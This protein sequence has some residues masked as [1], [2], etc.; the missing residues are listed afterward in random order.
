MAGYQHWGVIGAGA[1]GTSLAQALVRAGRDVTLWAREA[2]VV[3]AINQSH[4]NTPFLPKVRLDPRLKATKNLAD[5]AP[6][7]AWMLVAPAQHTRTL[8]EQLASVAGGR[9]VPAVLCSKGI[10]TGSLA[11]L[12]DIVKG[13]LPALPVAILSGPSFAIEVAQDQPTALTLACADEVLAASLCASISSRTLRP[14][15]SADVIGAQIGGAVKNVLAVA[16]GI[17]AG[18]GM[19]ENARAALITRGLAEMARLGLALGAKTETLMGLSGLGDLVLTCSSTQSRNMSLGFELGRGRTLA[20]ILAERKTVAEGVPTS[21]AAAALAMRHGV[22][23]PIV[24]GVD[25]ILNKGANV[26]EVI[27]G[28]LTRP[29]RSESN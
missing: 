24:M 19:G 12:S 1:W 20:D 17:A 2:E 13:V 23:M 25:S 3:D 7:E 10:E 4:C 6:C 27:E 9:A 26:A 14:Y 8:C 21:A 28:L 22:D 29:L 15:A 5:L 18:R 16:T 11:F